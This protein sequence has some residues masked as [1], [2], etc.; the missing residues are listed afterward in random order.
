MAEEPLPL[1]IE[2]PWKLAST[3]Q[4]LVAGA[5]AETSLSLFFFEPD[6]E[7]LTSKFP[8]DK[9][10]FVKVTATISPASFPAKLSRL[11]ASF[12]GEGI[13]CLHLLLDLN[14][15]NAAG[16]FGTIRPYFH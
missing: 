13:P 8:D 12:L 4:P 14:V 9:L 2:I 15:R 10:I 5:P 6:E 3:T 11:A 1:P 7:L 16:E